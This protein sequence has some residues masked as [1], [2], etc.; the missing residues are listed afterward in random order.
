VWSLD[1]ASEHALR[2]D[3]PV[4]DGPTPRP[5]PWLLHA[6]PVNTLNFCSFT[7]CDARDASGGTPAEIL[8]AVPTLLDSDSVCPP[9]S[10]LETR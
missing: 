8:L 7:V 10:R 5:Q 2:N 3:L 9:P 6:L 4:E 1:A